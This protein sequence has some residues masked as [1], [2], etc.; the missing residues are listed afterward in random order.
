MPDIEYVEVSA[1][2]FYVFHKSMKNMSINTELIEIN[3]K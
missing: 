1:K 2:T 3:Q